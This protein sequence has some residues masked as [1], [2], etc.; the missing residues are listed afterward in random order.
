MLWL[1]KLLIVG[2]TVDTYAMVS[3][4]GND[5]RGM[6]VRKIHVVQLHMSNELTRFDTSMYFII[7]P[8]RSCP[9][10]MCVEVSRLW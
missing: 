9:Q 8:L 5:I 1:G 2:V 3:I 6:P 10:T 4:R 7:T